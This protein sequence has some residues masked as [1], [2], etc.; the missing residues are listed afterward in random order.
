[1]IKVKAL[2]DFT[3]EKFDD[4][5]NIKRASARNK[6]GNIYLGDIFECNDKMAKYLTGDND[7]KITV[8]KV[9]ELEPKGKSIKSKK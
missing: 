7:Q 2:Q 5:Q 4:I 1:M 8:V 6:Y 9:L 3:L